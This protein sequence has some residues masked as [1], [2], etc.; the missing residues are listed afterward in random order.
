MNPKKKSHDDISTKNDSSALH[1]SIV[2]VFCADYQAID[3]PINAACLNSIASVGI[4]GEHAVQ[5]YK[6]N[7]S[8]KKT[9]NQLD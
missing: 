8:H 6:Y 1:V 4:C 7:G 3:N 5:R 9:L 2:D